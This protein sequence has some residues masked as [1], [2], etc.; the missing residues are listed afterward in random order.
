MDASCFVSTRAPPNLF[1][2][3]LRRVL[4]L[5]LTGLGTA[6]DRLTPAPAYASQTDYFSIELSNSA[7]NP[8]R[9]LP[10]PPLTIF[11]ALLTYPANLPN[12]NRRRR[13]ACPWAGRGLC[14]ERPHQTANPQLLDIIT[15]TIGIWPFLVGSRVRA[16]ART[17]PRG[18]ILD[19]RPGTPI[20]S[21]L[22]LPTISAYSS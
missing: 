12:P 3:I 6:F 22:L 20:I 10:S 1:L 15:A 14:A 8:Y 19:F 2:M 17:F 5:G 18:R 16:R 11:L 13:C 4:P 21:A 7:S 9:G